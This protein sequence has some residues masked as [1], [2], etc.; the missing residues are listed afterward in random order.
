MNFIMV[1]LIFFIPYAIW[2]LYRLT[3]GI[4][5]LDTKE[6]ER[7]NALLFEI[8]NK[9]EDFEKV[10][11]DTEIKVNFLYKKFLEQWHDEYRKKHPKKQN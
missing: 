7:L 8:N 6:Y 10:Q 9:L 5:V 1:A 3:S 2:Y 11:N 4:E